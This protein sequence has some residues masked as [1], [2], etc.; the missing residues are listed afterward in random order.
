MA[1]A[2]HKWDPI[3][4]P[5]DGLDRPVRI[6]P[7][8]VNG[9]TPGQA[10]GAKWRQTSNGLYV[11]TSVDPAIPEQRILEKS[12]LLPAGGAVT[13]WA[14]RRWQGGNFFDGLENDGRT[15]RPVP[16]AA[17]VGQSRRKR[18]GVIWTQD[19]LDPSEWVVLRGVPIAVPERALFDEVCRADGLMSAVQAHDMAFAAQ[20]T[21]LAAMSS[22][23]EEHPG[24]DGVPLARAALELADE[25]SLSPLE[26]RVR[27]IWVVTAGRPRPLV[28]RPVFDAR[29]G[30]HLGTPDLL[31]PVA[32][33]IGEVDGGEH[34]GAARRSHDAARDGV[35]R[36][37]G[38]ETFRVTSADEHRPGEIVRRIE[39]GYRRAA[40]LPAGERAWTLEPP[41]WWRPLDPGERLA[42][43]RELVR[44]IPQVSDAEAEAELR[45]MVGPRLS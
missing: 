32:R 38:L 6:D 2:L 3:C 15:P 7:S 33:V 13:G 21:S 39:D 14:S 12:M 17:G 41:P 18:D 10:R 26:S 20:L 43:E 29:T 44:S 27:V 1:R 35:F 28:N 34:A 8:G 40:R 25:G 11:P 36:D 24:W 9:P 22:Y 30:R 42:I 45:R 4:R 5:P 37:Y 23:V 16:L 31:D 19:R